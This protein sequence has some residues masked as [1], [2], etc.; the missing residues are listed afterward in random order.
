MT[1]IQLVE[2]DI[3]RTAFCDKKLPSDCHLVTYMNKEGKEQVDVVRAYTMSEIFD[4]YYD[5]LK[6]KGEV[7]SIE[8]G[9]GTIRPNLFGKIKTGENG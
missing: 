8:S 7:K 9:F 3:D 4:A 5:D 6:G 2:S 1:N